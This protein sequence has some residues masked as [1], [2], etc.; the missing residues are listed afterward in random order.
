MGSLDLNTFVEN[1][2]TT[3]IFNFEKMEKATK[4]AIR[5]L[6]NINT[7]NFDR[8]PLDGN[9]TAIT[10]GNKVGLGFT[11]LADMLIRMNLKYDSSE[12]MVFVDKMMKIFKNAS[13][14]AS[15]DLAVLNGSC[16]IID[17]YKNTTEYV[18][19]INHEYFKELTTIYTKKLKK[20]GIHNIGITTI[21]PNGSIGIIMQTSSG[22]EPIFSLSYERRV[23]EAGKERTYKVYHGL[24]KEYDDIF[25]ED[26]HLENENFITAKDINWKQR[27]K[28]QS[29][30]TKYITD[31]I[32]STINLPSE[33]TK[34]TISEIYIQSWLH[35]LKGITIYRDG[36]RDGILKES[37]KKFDILESVKFPKE[38]KA[39][40]KVIKSESRKWYVTY[41]LDEETKLPNSLFV[42]T[43]SSETNILTEDVLIHLEELAE[44]YIKDEHLEKLRKK[45]INQSNVVKITRTLSLLLR[46]RVPMIDII[47]TINLIHPPI[48]SFVFQIKK[49][50]SSFVEGDY[51]GSKCEDCGSQLQYE[52]G[53]EICMNCGYSKC[54]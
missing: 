38:Q 32:S 6:T 14:E 48:Y 35:N 16:D 33:A 46:H 34:E 54:G 41:S 19:F 27:V 20:Y 11:G 40:M 36:S 7:L 42:N 22:M 13:L 39:I 53:C 49:L 21:A 29:I 2:F 8:H 4:T 10:N 28:M 26:A 50:L 3:P 25:G 17:K 45:H 18:K 44:K 51:T 23:K 52:A 5:F 30:L 31:S 1:S 15:I 24:V 37:K 9:R 47:K 12:T 43:N